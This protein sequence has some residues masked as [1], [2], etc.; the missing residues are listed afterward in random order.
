MIHD[1]QLPELS[2]FRA[3]ERNLPFAKSDSLANLVAPQG[4]EGSPVHRWFRFKESF[5]A[6]FVR[7]TLQEIARKR[8][9]SRLDLLDPFCG[10]GTSLVAAQQCSAEGLSVLATG[11]EYNPFIH[12]VAET[13]ANWPAVDAFELLR[14]GAEI[15][16]QSVPRVQLPST[17]SITSGR[18]ISRHVARRLIM[19]RE[20]I[21]SNATVATRSAAL[22]GLA[23][24]IEGV[25]RTRKDGRALRI[26]ERPKVRVTG[27]VWDRWQTIADD[28]TFLQ[29]TIPTAKASRVIRGDGR[30]PTTAGISPESM[31]VIITSPPYPNNIDYTEVYK[32]ELWLLGM[33]STP[34]EFL[35]LRQGTFRSHPTT[36]ATPP[37]TDFLR[38]AK[39]GQLRRILWPLIERTSEMASPWRG[40]LLIGYFEDLYSALQQYL[41][42]LKRDGV[43]IF[44]IGNSLHGGRSDPYLI[45]TDLVLAELARAVGFEIESVA[46][47]RAFR[48]R[49]SGN[50]FLRESVVTVRKTHA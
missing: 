49:L 18:C 1:S 39:S 9:R 6:A 34:Q 29:A 35:M 3:A 5:S 32:L 20:L 28:V 31:D 17:S 11:I 13:K 47:A 42:V 46:V 48:R 14:M 33:V 30:Q 4:N 50:H 23:S 41:T 16:H 44:V 38:A 7:A 19:I 15:L 40:R 45:P 37:T 10:V 2:A 27:A 12:F 24:A 25:S 36:R 26:V 43:A 8:G 22:L 21:T